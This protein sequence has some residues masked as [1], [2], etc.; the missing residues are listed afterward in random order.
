MFFDCKHCKLNTDD[1]GTH[2]EDCPS[3]DP[4]TEF[5]YDFDDGD[6]KSATAQHIDKQFCWGRI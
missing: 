2:P 4:E 5:S 1:F 3:Y 6:D